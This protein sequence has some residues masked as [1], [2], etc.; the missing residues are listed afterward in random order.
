MQLDTGER[1]RRQERSVIACTNQ[2]VDLLRDWGG[3]LFL[4]AMFFIWALESKWE[5]K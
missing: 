1:I 4:L 5:K 3:W 2:W